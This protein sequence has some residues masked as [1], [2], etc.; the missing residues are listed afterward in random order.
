MSLKNWMERTNAGTFSV[1]S[2]KLKAIDQALA[3]YHAANNPQNLDR[4][5]SAFMAWM[6]EKGAGWKT[7]ERNKYGAVEEM[8]RDL[9]GGSNIKISF[10]EDLALGVLEEEQEKAL[11]NL[12]QGK[13]LV[14]RSVIDQ[15][16]KQKC[17]L[18]STAYA[19]AQVVPSSSSSGGKV[20]SAGKMAL[21]PFVY[22][23]RTLDCLIPAELKPEVVSYLADIMSGFMKELA[24]AVTPFVGI[25]SAGGSAFVSYGKALQAYVNKSLT[26]DHVDAGLSSGDPVAA[27]HAMMR[28]FERERNAQL[29]SAGVSTAELGGKLA[30][31][32]A[33]GGTATNAA[34]GMSASLAKM[35][36]IVRIIVRDT[37]EK[38]DANRYISM[39][40]NVGELLNA[41]VFQ[42]CPIL[43][44]YYICCAPTVAV[45]N[46]IVTA[47]RF[48]QAGWK[49]AVE[50]GMVQHIDP[51]RLQARLLIKDYRFVIP[52]LQHYP[53]VLSPNKDALKKMADDYA[54]R[55][56]L[57]GKAKPDMA[58]GA[59]RP[60]PPR[61]R[62]FDWAGQFRSGLPAKQGKG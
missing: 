25:I 30:G 18:T 7:S 50:A 57:A 13:R 14:R 58:V 21:T 1:R 23:E 29:Y 62:T 4:L 32:L 43:G 44:A 52:E 42:R 61:D 35:V 48:G 2:T 38:N 54:L 39:V 5:R 11:N 16:W 26:H 34:I 60:L 31:L 47:Q 10:D 27:M 56:L 45:L 51:L 41:Q 36:N 17:S 15:L 19:T 9:M 37:R 12:F 33:D 28:I 3:Q 59:L 22:A 6:T 8:S 46:Q 40:T 24:A 49:G 20:M 55:R 53:G